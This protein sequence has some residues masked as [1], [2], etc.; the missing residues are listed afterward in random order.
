VVSN[1]RLD[2]WDSSNAALCRLQRCLS[3]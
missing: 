3:T 2:R 1:G